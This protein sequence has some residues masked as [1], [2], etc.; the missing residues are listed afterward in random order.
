MAQ[1]QE[2]QGFAG[3][4]D[5]QARGSRHGVRGDVAVAEHNAFGGAG[6]SGGVNQRRQVLFAH[7]GLACLEFSAVG[8]GGAGHDVVKAGG[9]FGRRERE[10]AFEAGHVGAKRLHLVAELRV[11][12]KAKTH[13][14][15]VQNERVVGLRNRRVHRY[16]HAARAEDG[17][18]AEVPLGAV[19][20]RNNSDAVARLEAEVDEP[21]GEFLGL[22]NEFG[23]RHR[24]PLAVDFGVQCVGARM[25]S[26]R[27]VGEIK[28]AF[29][30]VHA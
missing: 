9:T 16:V 2:A 1:R 11:A 27:I 19:G 25:L 15:I 7:G 10:H 12:H 13:S 5:G 14:G 30:C 28:K 17:L 26:R 23:G 6:G 3:G 20:G 18:V 29:G 8:V 22:G 21:A 4:A 24:L